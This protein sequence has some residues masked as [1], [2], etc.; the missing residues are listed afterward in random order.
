VRN[1]ESRAAP[2]ATPAAAGAAEAD[3]PAEA[4]KPAEAPAAGGEAKPAESAKPAEAAKPAAE[5]AP[6]RPTLKITSSPSG[7]DVIIDGN[8]VGTTPFTSRD[9][10]ATAPHGIT[11]K[12]DGFEPQDRMIGTSDWAA[13]KGG[14]SL[15][16]N[17]KL[18]RVGPAPAQ[19]SGGKAS[20]VEILTPDN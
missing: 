4:A 2:T 9:V 3:K 20:D 7:A 12:K 13:K 10:D 19:E 14:P 8:V 16:V 15:K 1:L 6:E 17:I 18:R 5:A 11:V